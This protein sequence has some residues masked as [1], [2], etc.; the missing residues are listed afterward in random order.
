MDSIYVKQELIEGEDENID[1]LVA[2]KA[3]AVYGSFFSLGT[4]TGPLAG[5]FVYET[6]T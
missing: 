5:S 3:S 4:I 2:D 6:L 1:S